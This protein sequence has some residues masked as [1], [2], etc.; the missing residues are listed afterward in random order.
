MTLHQ[1]RRRVPLK[2]RLSVGRRD[3]MTTQLLDLIRAGL[4]EER[5]GCA[6]GGRRSSE[7][8]WAKEPYEI[9]RKAQ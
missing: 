1:L 8:E 5:G 6:D 7:T 4:A 9:R 2:Y 3:N